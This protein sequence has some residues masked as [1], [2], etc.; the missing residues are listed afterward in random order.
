MPFRPFALERYFAEHEFA[1]EHILSASDPESLSLAE[2]L[3]L[4][5]AESL[6]LW[7]DLKLGYTESQG[8]SLLRAEIARLY[9]SIAARDVLVAVP[10]EAIFIAM[11]CLLRP[12]DHVVATFPAYQSLYEVA[13]GL[14]C[15]VTRWPLREDGEHWRL[16]EAE[17]EASLRPETRLIVVNFPHNPTGYL[18][19][20]AFFERVIALAARRGLYLFSDEMYRLLEYEPALRLPAAC[21]LYERAVSLSGLSK[22]FALPGLRLG[23][24][25]SRDAELLAACAAFKDYTTIC[26]SAPSEIL[27]FMAL[28]AR[29]VILARNRALITANLALAADFF[30]RHA[31][32]FVWLPP[33]AGSV[34]LPRLRDGRASA[35]LSEGLLHARNVL[36]L[37]GNVFEYGPEYFRLGLGRADFPQGLAQLEDYLAGH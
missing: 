31:G 18:P 26:A 23:W 25:A 21:D 11:H 14:G 22:S 3:T 36:L 12:G 6:Q 10:E 15:E 34:C 27:G 17:L 5:D 19:P 28:R 37:P 35:D 16:D 8:H 30:A 1:V 24:L 4:S 13:A 33:Q 29:E 9:A 20:R 7:Q 32:R 2:L